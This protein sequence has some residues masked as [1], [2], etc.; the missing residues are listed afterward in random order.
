MSENITEEEQVEELK[1]WWAENSRAIIIGLVIGLGGVFGWK[2]W[3]DYQ[4][5]MGVQAS[6]Q[7]QQALHALDRGARDELDS[8]G[9]Q[10][11]KE[12]PRTPYPAMA[13]LAMAKAAFEAKDGE[14]ARSHLQWVVDNSSDG[15]VV[16]IARL[17]LSRILLDEGN[18][19][20]ALKLIGST[21]E[22]FSVAYSEQRGD[23]YRAKGLYDKAAEAYREALSKD[24]ASKTF[25]QM[26]LEDVLSRQTGV[27]K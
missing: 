21:S 27:D 17:R 7:Y 25:I 22:A 15:E 9:N 14:A 24:P 20:A 5:Q 18:P 23:I 1:K 10:L 4:Q 16:Q 26:K 3:Q 13:K 19:D 2:S 12:Y 8:L 11:V 6:V